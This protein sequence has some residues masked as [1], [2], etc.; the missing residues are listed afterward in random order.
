MPTD[1]SNQIERTLPYHNIVQK[2][3][4]LKSNLKK[5][6][7]GIRSQITKHFVFRFT[8]VLLSQTRNTCLA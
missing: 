7:L 8:I 4:K 5:K 6:T 3:I 2:K 1:M